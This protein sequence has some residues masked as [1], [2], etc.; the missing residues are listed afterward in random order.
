MCDLQLISKILSHILTRTRAPQQLGVHP[1]GV[2]TVPAT[3]SKQAQ[4]DVTGDGVTMVTI[5]SHVAIVSAVN[6]WQDV[7]KEFH[8]SVQ[9]RRN[10]IP[11]DCNINIILVMQTHKHTCMHALM[12]AHTGTQIYTYTYAHMQMHTHTRASTHACTH[13]D[14]HTH[15]CKHA[16]MHTCTNTHTH[17]RTHAHT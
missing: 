15:T 9:G 17:T 1:G 11:S 2:Y 8:S 13:A 16:C 5:V 12:H 4:C 6:T 10:E 3:I 14:A 7:H